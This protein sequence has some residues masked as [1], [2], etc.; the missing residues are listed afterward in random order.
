MHLAL[1]GKV[2]VIVGGTTGLGLSAARGFLA[3]EARVVTV[4]RTPESVAAAEVVLGEKALAFAGDAT[5][6]E[7][8]GARRATGRCTS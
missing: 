5:Q 4:G 2:F 6:L 8:A 7:A 1:H 3:A